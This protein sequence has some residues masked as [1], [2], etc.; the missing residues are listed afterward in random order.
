MHRYTNIHRQV[1]GQTD[2]HIYTY[3]NICFF[4]NL[5]RQTNT[6][7]HTHTHTH[8]HVDGQTDRQTNTYILQYL[9]LL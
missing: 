4:Y 8:R 5:V 3:F 1:D 6:H 7:T 9:V 2:K